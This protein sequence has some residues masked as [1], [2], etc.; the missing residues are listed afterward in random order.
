MISLYINSA[1]VGSSRLSDLFGQCGIKS[2]NEPFNKNNREKSFAGDKKTIL[3]YSDLRLK[4]IKEAYKKNKDFLFYK[5]IFD[6]Y[7][8]SPDF[9]LVGIQNYSFSRYLISFFC[10]IY[11]CLITQRRN[12]D[13]YISFKKANF[14]KV[15]SNKDTTNFKPEADAEEFYRKSMQM[16]YFYNSCY[17]SAMNSH[18]NISIINYEDWADE[19]DNNQVSKVRNLLIKKEIKF[20]K[21]TSQKIDNNNIGSQAFNNEYKL[22]NF[23]FRKFNSSEKVKRKLF[24]QDNTSFWPDKISNSTEF[25]VK[26]RELGIEKLLNVSPINI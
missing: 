5:K 13:Q 21:L 22:V 26:C 25:L 23:S 20:S 1:R 2:Y 6:A 16:Y 14:Y 8:R 4:D 19:S 10:G 17:F 12:I 7:A 11:P 3:K 24:K 9:H 18:R 15:F